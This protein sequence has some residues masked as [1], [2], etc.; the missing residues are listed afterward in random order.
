MDLLTGPLCG[1]HDHVSPS[2]V[3]FDGLGD[4]LRVNATVKDQHGNVMSNDTITWTASDR[5]IATVSS[6]GLVTAVGPGTSTVTA[7]AGSASGTAAVTVTQTPTSLEL[8]DTVIHFYSVGDTPSQATVRDKNQN[9]IN[10]SPIAGATSDASVAGVFS[11]WPYSIIGVGSA[12]IT[13]TVESLKAEARVTIALGESITAGQ[14]HS[15]GLMV[16]GTAY[17][18]GS[19]GGDNSVTAQVV[20]VPFQP[21]SVAGIPGDRYPL[22]KAIPVG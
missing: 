8:S 15:C 17:C 19:N 3:T 6:S 20:T 9:P 13:V 1:H 7:S 16:T 10:D 5:G 21:Q 22:E 4:D 14:I 11:R 12:T 2:E 18:W